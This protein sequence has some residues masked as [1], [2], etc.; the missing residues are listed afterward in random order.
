[1]AF[2]VIV[3]VAN[4]N[5]T[6]NVLTR[7]ATMPASISVGNLLLAFVAS[8][9]AASGTTITMTGWTSISN[10]Q[11]GSAV[12]STVFARVADGT[13]GATAA[14]DTSASEAC[15]WHF[16]N[17][18]TWFGTIA[19]GC[20]AGTPAAAGSTN[21]NPPSLTPSWGALDTMWL[22]GAGNDGNVAITAGPASYTNFVNT[23]WANTSGCGIATARRELNTATEDPGTFTMSTEQWVAHTIAIRPAAA[24]GGSTQPPRSMHQF[25]LRAA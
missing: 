3:S 20:E 17:I 13:E 14:I 9:I 1:V 8:D 25:R 15:A 23:R 6:S 12:R 21:P 11:F 18:S 7:N 5:D 19:N 24:G 10:Q 16:Y 22:A 2:P 4:G